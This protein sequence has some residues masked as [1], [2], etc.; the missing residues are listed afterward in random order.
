[1]GSVPQRARLGDGARGLQPRR[2][3]LG[4]PPARPRPLARLPVERGRHRRHLGPAPDALLRGRAVERRGSDPEGAALRPHRSGGQPRR[5]LQGAVLVP[6]Q[7]AHPLVH[8]DALQVSAAP[9]PVR[10]ADPPEPGSGPREP[11]GRAPRHRGPRRGPVLRR[12]GGLRQGRR[13]GHPGSH[14][15][16]QSRTRGRPPPPPPDALVPECLVV[17]RKRPPAAARGPS[18][19]DRP[20]DG[21]SH[22]APGRGKLHPAR[23]RGRRVALHRER[24]QRPAAVGR[25]ERLA[26]REGRV[27]RP[28]HRGSHR[29]GQSRAGGNQVR[30]VDPAHVASRGHADRPSP[31]HP[32]RSGGAGQERR[33]RRLRGRVRGA[34]D[35]GRRV[36]RQGHPRGADRGRP[37]CHAPG[38]RGD[39]LEQAVLPLRRARLAGGRPRS[40]AATRGTEGRPER[41]LGPPA[42]RRRPEHAGQVGVPLVRG[43][44]P[45]L[46]L[47]PARA[48]RLRLRQG[49]ARSAAP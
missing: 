37:Q 23:R 20:R 43:L 49:A 24:D 18:G 11:R 25:A 41:G 40:S 9:V 35:R 5:G 12:P 29:A 38:A 4:R 7:H 36:L 14:P 17:G 15:G 19:C 13:R 3:G 21:R 45:R 44:G 30:G 39:A 10:G 33:G 34:R 16:E 28:G 22:P 32:G 46:P 47:H 27:P 6:R 8:A 1:M 26:V 2:H 42:Q 31:A 48:G